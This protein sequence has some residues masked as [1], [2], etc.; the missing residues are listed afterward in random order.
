M[1]APRRPRLTFGAIYR[2]GGA[3]LRH[4]LLLTVVFVCG[5]TVGVGAYTFF[6][7]DTAGLDW[8]T[9]PNIIAAAMTVFSLGMLREQFAEVKRRLEKLETF[10]EE[11]LPETYARKDV[12]EAAGFD[13]RGDRP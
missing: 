12:L 11:T 8:I 2:A 5:L 7:A 10:N 3:S 6:A 13:E 1:S 9:P 4:Q